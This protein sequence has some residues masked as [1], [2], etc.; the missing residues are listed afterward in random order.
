[1]HKALGLLP[2][3][4]NSGVVMDAYLLSQDWGRRGRMIR[5]FKASR[6]TGVADLKRKGTEN[7]EATVSA[8]DL[9]VGWGFGGMI[10]FVKLV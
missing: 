3:M 10:T 1:M 9:V 8:V 2:A 6:D 4:K 5:Q 7:R